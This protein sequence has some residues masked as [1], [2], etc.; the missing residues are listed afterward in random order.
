MPL[1]D[2][3]FGGRQGES[4]SASRR[5]ALVEAIAAAAREVYVTLGPGYEESVY[6]SAL[7]VEFRKRGLS[8]Q[9]EKNVEVLYKGETVGIHR[10]DF[11]VENLAVLELKAQQ[12][13]TGSHLAQA[14][15]YLKNL[16]LGLGMVVNFPLSDVGEPQIEVLDEEV[17]ERPL[18]MTPILPQ[19]K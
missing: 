19:P 11:V 2:E 10:I 6:Q 13:L 4:R 8:Y 15:A 5:H 18:Q 9:L 1:F 14:R 16:G 7:A 3:L 17:P 12:Q